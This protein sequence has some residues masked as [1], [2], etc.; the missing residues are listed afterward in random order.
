MRIATISQRLCLITG[1]G[2]IDVHAA[3]GGQFGADPAAVYSYWQEF[4]DWPARRS[5]TKARCRIRPRLLL[6]RWV[7]RL[8]LRVR[9]LA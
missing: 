2:A 4:T 9:Y 6:T 1:G 8:Q 3:S 5:P 7:R